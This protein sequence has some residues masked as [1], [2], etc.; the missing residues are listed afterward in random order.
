MS[1]TALSALARLAERRFQSFSE[2]ADAVLA[3]LESAL[4]GGSVLVGHV[5]WE[6]GEYRLIDVR[7]ELASELPPGSVL[8]I[9]SD[10]KDAGNG[11]L[12]RDTLASLSVRSYL[13][14]PPSPPAP[15]ST[16]AR[17]WT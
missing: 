16:P 15:I 8:P 13:A 11:L 10:G 7:G 9:D 5:D 2:A 1:A 17:T 12:N 3:L 6:G 4:P 14:M